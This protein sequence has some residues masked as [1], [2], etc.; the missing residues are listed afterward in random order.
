MRVSVFAGPQHSFTRAENSIF[1]V[2][3]ETVAR[4]SWHW[5]GGE[6][7]DWS[8]PR[9][10]LSASVFRKMSDGGG[11]LGPVQLSGATLEFRR[12]LL[13][14]WTADLMASYDYNQALTG[15]PRT[16]SD[17]SAACGMSRMLSQNLSLDFRYWR[18]PQR[19]PC[20]LSPRSSA[21]YAPLPTPAP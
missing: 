4:S 20:D 2:G 7:Y 9:A 6:T 8:G 10:S 1:I 3:S 11:V 12:Q 21:H 15:A 16:L 14:R 17:V 13:Q 5:A 18:L 19:G